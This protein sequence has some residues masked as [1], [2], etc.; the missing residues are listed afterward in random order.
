MILNRSLKLTFAILQWTKTAN[1]R[2]PNLLPKRRKFG[3]RNVHRKD[4]G[5]RRPVGYQ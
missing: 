1:N 5:N 4:N 2:F 3:G